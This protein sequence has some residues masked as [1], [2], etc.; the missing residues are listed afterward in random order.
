[1]NTLLIEGFTMHGEYGIEVLYADFY[2]W[3]K[4]HKSEELGSK[5]IA[6]S[7]KVG[8]ESFKNILILAKYIGNNSPTPQASSASNRHGN[9]ITAFY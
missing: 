6:Y 5:I 2:N 7:W 9:P 3:L 8:G 1:M 4:L